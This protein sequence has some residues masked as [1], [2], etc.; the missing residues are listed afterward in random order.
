MKFI[1]NEGTQLPPKRMAILG[2]LMR[3]LQIGTRNG[4]EA[5]KTIYLTDLVME[6]VQQRPGFVRFRTGSC[7]YDVLAPT[8][9]S[10]GA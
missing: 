1:Q 4:I 2:R 5:G 7:T 10:P 8:T 3:P 9:L 6:I